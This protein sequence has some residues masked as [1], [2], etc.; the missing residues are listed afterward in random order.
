VPTIA[1]ARAFTA[2][3]A[4]SQQE[5]WPTAG[6]EELWRRFR[7]EALGTGT[8]SWRRSTNRRRLRPGAPRPANGTYRFEI[9]PDTRDIWV[10]SSDFRRLASLNRRVTDNHDALYQA[11]FV[12]DDNLAHVERLGPGTPD[13]EPGP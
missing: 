12:A 3:D 1:R 4:L 5:E 7:A 9:D 2:I 11:T 8:P 13:W 10:L 6:T